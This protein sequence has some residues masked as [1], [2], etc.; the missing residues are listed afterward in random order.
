MQI[1]FQ[2]FLA[3]YWREIRGLYNVPC[4]ERSPASPAGFVLVEY[5][6][7]SV[8]RLSPTLKRCKKC[9]WLI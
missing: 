7:V 3:G 1:C 2:R 5:T 9:E 8:K 4:L 6:C